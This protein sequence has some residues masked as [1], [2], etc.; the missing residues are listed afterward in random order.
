MKIRSLFI[1]AV[2]L[3]FLFSTA[4]N[5][6]MG[7]IG[8]EVQPPEDIV[9]VKID[10]FAMTSTTF[11][12]DSICAKSINGLLGNFDD[13][14][15]GNLRS[16]YMTQLYCPEGNGFPD[17][18]IN[19]KIDSIDLMI[20]YQTATGDTLAPMQL[21][22]YKVTKPLD[23]NFYTNID[24]SEYCDLNSPIGTQVYTA[25]GIGTKD[26]TITYTD[27]STAKYK[28]V[29][30]RLPKEIGQDMFEK[31]RVSNILSSKEAFNNYFPG[32]Y[33]TTTYGTGSIIEVLS[34]SL[35]IYFNYEATKYQGE[36]SIY[37][38]NSFMSLYA[39]K[40]IIQL[41]HFKNSNIE[42][43]LEPNET[44]AYIK[45][46]AGVFTEIDIPMDEI[47]AKIDPND[48][49]V[50]TNRVAFNVKAYATPQDTK[51]PLKAPNYM[52]IIPADEYNDFF[53]NY[54]Q[55]TDVNSFIGTYIAAYDTT[56]LVY[57]FNNL[58]PLIKKIN[59]K[60]TYTGGSIKAYLVPV[61]INFDSNNNVASIGHYLKPAAVRIRK[62]KENINFTIIHS[63]F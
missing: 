41:N 30:I 5:D 44:T 38:T 2:A 58:S 47:N 39:T 28:Y 37:V 6:D 54:K 36:D 52:M 16:D 59:E 61:T 56:N 57:R 29:R 31:S 35:N 34:T 49:D 25:S 15:F 26:S 8:F 53:E 27:G 18:V 33:F 63:K 60:D 19:N 21:S 14:I 3:T 7:T 40:E 17:S 12:V 23:K 55:P 62:D 9:P 51:Y 13:P 50:I 10:T 45:T 4:C 42:H 46:P 11:K 32:I 20:F 48:S 43:L 1:S 22:A 24:P